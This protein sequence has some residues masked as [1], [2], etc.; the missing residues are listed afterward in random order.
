MADSASSVGVHSRRGIAAR[1]GSQV[2]L[3]R[4]GLAGAANGQIGA[5]VQAFL[6]QPHQV[7]QPALRTRAVEQVRVVNQVQVDQFVMLAHVQGHVELG[8]RRHQPF[9]VRA[10]VWMRERGFLRAA[11]AT[12]N[13][14]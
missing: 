13:R 9:A 7:V 1:T 2:G 4:P 10:D 8:L 14:G 12:W 6:Q 11:F 5:A 3:S